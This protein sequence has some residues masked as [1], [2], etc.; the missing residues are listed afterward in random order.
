MA[1]RVCPEPFSGGVR[2]KA[3][4]RATTDSASNSVANSASVLD[5]V[6][7]RDAK[8]F[9]AH[10][11]AGCYVRPLISGEYGPF[12]DEINYTHVLVT[13][14]FSGARARTGLRIFSESDAPLTELVDYRSGARWLVTYDGMLIPKPPNTCEAWQM[15][16]GADTR[17]LY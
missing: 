14:M 17:K 6:S 16:C 2:G 13:Q 3:E 9:K 10:P 1:K 15:L 12:E 8:W 7:T 5:A 4:N 11:N